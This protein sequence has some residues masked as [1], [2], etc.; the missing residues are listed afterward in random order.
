MRLTSGSCHDKALK[1]NK[2]RTSVSGIIESR[3]SGNDG[4]HSPAGSAGLVN[5]QSFRVLCDKISSLEKNLYLRCLNS[6]NNIGQAVNVRAEFF[7]VA[8]CA[9]TNLF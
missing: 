7:K 2:L 4:D 9:V 1:A 5:L 8:V 6:F 3:L